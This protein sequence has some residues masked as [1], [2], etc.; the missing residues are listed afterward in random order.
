MQ[1]SQHLSSV[2]AIKHFAEIQFLAAVFHPSI[3]R[4]N[5]R[6]CTV[7]VHFGLKT[8]LLKTKE[9]KILWGRLATQNLSG[10]VT[11]NMD[12]PVQFFKLVQ[13]CIRQYKGVTYVYQDDFTIS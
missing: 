4:S 9:W 5:T 10:L 12:M 7:I 13:K 1:Y 8:S 2:D 11:S 3:R 6:L